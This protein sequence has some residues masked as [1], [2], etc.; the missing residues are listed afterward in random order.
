[1]AAHS[2]T[3]AWEIPWTEQPC[4]L[5]S[6]GSPRVEDNLTTKPQQPCSHCLSFT[7]L[8]LLLSVIP[9]MPC[10]EELSQHD[11]RNT[12]SFT[13]KLSPPLFLIQVPFRVLSSGFSAHTQHLQSPATSEEATVRSLGASSGKDLHTSGQPWIFSFGSLY[14]WPCRSCWI[15]ERISVTDRTCQLLMSFTFSL[16]SW[17]GLSGLWLL[18]SPLHLMSCVK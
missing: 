4:G 1:M 16:S 9:F 12:F 10:L 3:L 5:Q 18:T 14:L 6:M 8:F 17:T 7:L 15:P 2:S 13:S 11:L